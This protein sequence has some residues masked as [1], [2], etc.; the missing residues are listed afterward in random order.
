[1]NPVHSPGS[2]AGAA[3]P[4]ARHGPRTYGFVV[5]RVNVSVRLQLPVRSGS[6]ALTSC[7]KV[8]PTDSLLV[9]PVQADLASSTRSG[10]ASE[11]APL[12]SWPGSEK[13]SVA[14]PALLVTVASWSAV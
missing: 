6:V 14:S 2:T 3:R 8:M 10:C 7:R 5:D 1:M 9:G 4:C 11:K 13:E 12:V